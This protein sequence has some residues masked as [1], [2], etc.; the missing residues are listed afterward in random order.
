MGRAEGGAVGDSK[1]DQSSCSAYEC[2]TLAATSKR[3]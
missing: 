1:D 2:M 3:A